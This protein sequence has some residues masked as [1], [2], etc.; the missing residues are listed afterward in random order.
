LIDALGGRTQEWSGQSDEVR[1]KRDRFGY[2]HAGAD[3][4]AGKY[5]SIGGRQA[6]VTKQLGRR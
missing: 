4:T 3:P 1:S 6:G 2:I 5:Q